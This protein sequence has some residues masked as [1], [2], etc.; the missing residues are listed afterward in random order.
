MRRG[1]KMIVA[2]LAA[3]GLAVAASEKGSSTDPPQAVVQSRASP[4]APPE[5]RASTSPRAPGQRAPG[6]RQRPLERLKTP[7]LAP[8]ANIPLPQDI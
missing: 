4:E 5:G 6:P 2:C 1:T 3:L 8:N 7:P